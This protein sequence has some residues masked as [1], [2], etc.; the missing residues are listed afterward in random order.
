MKKILALALL[1]CMMPTIASAK[2]AT[3]LDDSASFVIAK[4]VKLGLGEDEM[5][6]APAIGGQHKVKE[7]KHTATKCSK[8]EDCEADQYCTM[9]MCKDLCER[10]RT[11]KKVK[12]SGETPVCTPDNH[13]SYCA[14]TPE[15][16]NAAWECRKVSGRY[17]CEPC[18]AGEKCGCPDGK[19]S[20]GSGKCVTCN[21]D[22]DCAD[23]EYCSNSG[24]EASSC[25]IVTCSTGEYVGNHQ[26]NSCSSAIPGCTDCTSASNCTSCEAKYQD[27][28]GNGGGC[29][30][31]TCSSGQYLNEDDGNCYPCSNG[32]KQCTSSTNCQA[33]ED[34]YE[35]VSGAYCELRGCAADQYLNMA[36]GQCYSCPA[37]CSSCSTVMSSEE[38]SACTACVDGYKLSGTQCVQKSC[39]DMGYSTSCGEGQDSVPANKSG[40][41]GACYTCSAIAGYCTSDSDCA[42]NQKCV[43]NECVGKTCSEINSSYKTSCSNGYSSTSTGVSGS[44]GACYTCS[45]I[46][47]YCTSDSDCASNQKCV[48]NSCV[49]KTCAE[50][51]HKSSCNTADGYTAVN[52]NVTGSDGTCYDCNV[53]SCPSGYS[54]STTSCSGGYALDTD[55]KSDGK[56]CG[57]CVKTGCTS[58][59]DCGNS[60]Y[61]SNYICTTV[62]CDTSNGY[63]VSNHVCVETDCPLGYSASTTSCSGGY[64][65]D[66]DGKSGGKACGKCVA[67]NCPSGYSTSVTSC[68]SGYTL[69]TN[70]YSGDNACSKCEAANCP[71]GYS[72]SVTSCDSGYTLKTNGYSGDN[73]CGKCEEANCP[74]GYSTSVTSCG[75]GY[76]LKTNGYSGGKAC[77]KCEEA[78]CPSGYSTSVTSCTGKEKLE[79]NGSS[80]GKA[81]GKCVLKTCKEMGYATSCGSEYYSQEGAYVVGS[82]GPC[83]ICNMCPPGYAT[84][85]INCGPGTYLDTQGSFNGAPC[86]KCLSSSTCEALGYHTYGPQMVCTPPIEVTVNGLRCYK[87]GSSSG[88]SCEKKYPSPDGTYRDGA[89]F[90]YFIGSAAKNAWETSKC[91]SHL[92][93]SSVKNGALYYVTIKDGFMIDHN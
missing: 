18:S 10:N 14:C 54:T 75:S 67:A 37:A 42:S 32:C 29:V 59:S 50:L 60:Q 53:A 48:N 22:S 66:T 19:M 52:A 38:T 92:S 78:N 93:C 36:D 33:C 55:G 6:G 61:C 44:D 43:N 28:S 3:Y 82:D 39:S 15:S 16:C 17:S 65:L 88:T 57:K 68:G 85:T 27:P 9:G 84:S 77:G 70:G 63:T 11:K 5:R 12:C 26:C 4:S 1:A 69:K 64:T 25:S 56:A 40:S 41:D 76:T 74:S 91:A 31:T 2:T 73:A 8:N 34:A 49:L 23:D 46:S 87:C 81:C 20:N 72:T 24:T 13:D 79:T 89:D 7:D 21:F 58:D 71:S 83:F 35:L 86:G 47:G 51:G 45:A 90:C 62:P 30:M 80:G